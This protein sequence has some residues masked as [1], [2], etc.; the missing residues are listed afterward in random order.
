[1]NVSR[2]KKRSKRQTCVSSVLPYY[3]ASFDFDNIVSVA[4][5]T[6]SDERY[7]LSNFGART[8][9]LAAPGLDIISTAVGG[10]DAYALDEGTSLAAA[11]VSGA[12]ALLR[13]RYP[14]ETAQQ[15]I[16]RLLAGTDPLG[17]LAGLCVTGG[18]L[19]LRKALESTVAA[20]ARLLA[21]PPAS[22]GLFQLRLTGE[23]Q[24]T[25]VIQATTNLL[26]WTPVY[27]NVAAADGHFLYT[28][29][30]ATDPR[31]AFFRAQSAE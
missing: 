4:A 9:D 15:I 23:P 3:P 14:T 24:H 27:T 1:V 18:R 31:R 19:N 2:T 8:V 26:D 25:Y 6:R 20:P 22:S 16:Q 21:L 17:G 30:P 5:T 29:S 11:Y 28:N 10:D 12:C 13:A 7:L